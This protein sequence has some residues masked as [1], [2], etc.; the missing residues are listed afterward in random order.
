MLRIIPPLQLG[1]ILKYY[2]CTFFEASYIKFKTST[3]NDTKDSFYFPLDCK[4]PHFSIKISKKT[5]F[6][7]IFCIL[8]PSCHSAIRFPIRDA[9]FVDGPRQG[10]GY[11]TR[12]PTGYLTPCLAII[13]YMNKALKLNITFTNFRY[14]R[15]QCEIMFSI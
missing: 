6:S 5:F 13:I 7:L 1:D 8:L 15:F 14:T 10:V 3:I 11:L 12:R 9:I 4:M 2:F